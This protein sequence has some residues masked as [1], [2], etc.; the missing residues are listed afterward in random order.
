[1]SNQGTHNT[2]PVAIIGTGNIGSDLLVKVLRSP[3][4]TCAMFTGQHPDSPGIARARELNIPTSADSIAAIE[5]DPG[6][7][8][9]VFDATTAEAHRRHAT[10]LARLK[11]FVIDMTPSQAGGMCVPLLNLEDSLAKQNVNMVTCGGQANAP[12]ARAIMAVHPD[13]Q[14]MEVV[15]SI[16]SKSAGIGTRN[17]IDEYTQTTSDGIRAL[18]GVPQVKTIIILNPAD[19]PYL[20]HNTLYAEI[21]R[22]D[23]PALERSIK[24]TVE[25]IREYVPG[26]RLLYGPVQ[27]SGR[28]TTITEVVGRGDYLPAYAG[29]LDIINC[30]AVAVAERYAKKK[31]GLH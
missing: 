14:Y 2:I 22:P 27:E 23:L 7:C 4:L 3:Y 31:L 16:A 21:E 9:I 13:I 10:V 1:M 29:N 28:V 24:H 8:D 6:C 18:A 26:F 5:R 11:K 12:I 17:N 25:K 19:P 30:A 15:S 20:M